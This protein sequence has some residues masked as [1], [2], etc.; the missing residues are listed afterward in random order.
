MDFSSR[1]FV[2]FF[3]VLTIFVLVS[4]PSSAQNLGIWKV[5][6]CTDYVYNGGEVPAVCC[7]GIDA[8]VGPADT[9][10]LRQF[11]CETFKFVARFPGILLDS[12]QTLPEKCGQKLDF[13]ISPVVDCSKVV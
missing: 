7:D 9:T 10:I 13:Q 6:F 8:F 2:G 11:V 5:A 3:L 1:N 4:S 12:L